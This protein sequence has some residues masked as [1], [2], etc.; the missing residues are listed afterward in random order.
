MFKQERGWLNKI[1]ANTV[2]MYSW[3][4]YLLTPVAYEMI[5]IVK[6]NPCKIITILK[7][8]MMGKIPYSEYGTTRPQWY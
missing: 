8:W 2:W 3:K 7:A 4:Y 6:Y 5:F 1:I